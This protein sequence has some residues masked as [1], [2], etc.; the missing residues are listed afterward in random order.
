M[1]IG[2]KQ[3]GILFLPL[4]HQRYSG[5]SYYGFAKYGNVIFTSYPNR[6]YY[7]T[8]DGNTAMLVGGNYMTN[9][10]YAYS[11]WHNGKRLIMP[12]NGNSLVN[13]VA[14]GIEYS[15]GTM[16]TTVGDKPFYT[17]SLNPQTKTDFACLENM[18]E[19]ESCEQTWIVIPTGEQGKTYDFFTVY[20]STLG[21]EANTPNVNITI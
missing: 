21:G 13:E 10:F 2:S 14:T 19:G 16:S 6:L 15:K 12:Y 7:F 9:N 4:Q 8:I 11:I 5:T 3:D 17:T 18:Q 1:M 20:D